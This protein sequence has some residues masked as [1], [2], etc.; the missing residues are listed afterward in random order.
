MSKWYP[1][2]I[3]L[4]PQF[5]RLDVRVYFEKVFLL[6]IPNDRS[7]GV[8]LDDE[9][10]RLGQ[11]GFFDVAE[12]FGPFHLFHRFGRGRDGVSVQDVEW[13]GEEPEIVLGEL[14][15]PPPDAAEAEAVVLA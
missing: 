4:V 7:N 13:V 3:A 9:W 1:P 6:V 11:A 2:Q 14:P 12:R 10:T 8:L 5:Q 15:G